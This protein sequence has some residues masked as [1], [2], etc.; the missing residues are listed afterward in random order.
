[1]AILLILVL[2]GYVYSNRNMISEINPTGKF[3]LSNPAKIAQDSRQNRYII[4]N[5]LKRV[6]KIN[7]SNKVDFFINGGMRNTRGFGEGMVEN[8]SEA[9]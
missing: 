8:A 9:G 6:V 4:E 1:M 2:G 3:A 5:S 7:S